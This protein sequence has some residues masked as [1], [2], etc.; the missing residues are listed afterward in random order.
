M[1]NEIIFSSRIGPEHKNSKVPEAR[2]A[3]GAKVADGGGEQRRREKRRGKRVLADNCS[4]EGGGLLEI[5]NPPNGVAK[6]I[7][8]PHLTHFQSLLS[9][10]FFR[11]YFLF[12]FL[13]FFFFFC[14]IKRG[15]VICKAL[16]KPLNCKNQ[17]FFFLQVSTFFSPANISMGRPYPFS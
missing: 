9:I 17:T 15:V 11:D 5:P 1:R 12:L 16:V 13:W 4:W 14:R 2:I 8:S 3:T 7:H 10:S 6:G